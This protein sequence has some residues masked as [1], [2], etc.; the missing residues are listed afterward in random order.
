MGVKVYYKSPIVWNMILHLMFSLAFIYFQNIY[1]FN[2]SILNEGFYFEFAA[3]NWPFIGLI[4]LT[5]LLFFNNVTK[6]ASIFFLAV[7]GITMFLTTYYLFLDFSKLPVILLFFYLL[8]GF[9]LFQFYYVE[10]KESYYN[11]IFHK[12]DLF[13]P[14]N[15]FAKVRLVRGPESIP[16]DGILTNWSEEGCFIY[17]GGAQALKG[18]YLI[19][20]DFS[21]LIFKE[22]ATVISSLTDKTGHGFKFKHLRKKKVNNSLGWLKFYE[23]MSEL[24]YRP[25][26]LR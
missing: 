13:A 16:I 25:E 22:Q 17:F 5:I 24:G 26:L 21:D 18:K 1:R 4:G 23:I 10:I 15:N 19:E 14:E 7:M 12:N 2:T 11:P 8:F 20:I 3:E 9:Y 6:L